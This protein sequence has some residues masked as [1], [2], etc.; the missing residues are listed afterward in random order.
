M[1]YYIAFASIAA[2]GL[3]ACNAPAQKEAVAASSTTAEAAV[4]VPKD[5]L[6]PGTPPGDEGDWIADIRNG[7]ADI[8]EL[9]AKDAAAA[10]KKALELY[11]TRQEY[12][13]MYYGVNGRNKATPELAEAIATAETRFH[14][15]MKLLSS[16][17][18]DAGEVKAAVK[19]LDR[20]EHTVA[21]LWKASGKHLQRPAN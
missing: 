5:G 2:L 11:V 4:S 10:Q 20:Q 15:L 17:T 3:A 16:T 6:I 8:P 12:S 7:I 18:P 14:D 19:A 1:R 9:A 21:K 13:E